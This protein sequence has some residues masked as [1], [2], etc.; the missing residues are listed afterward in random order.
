MS[1]DSWKA[2]EGDLRADEVET[3]SDAPRIQQ[4]VTMSA[5]LQSDYLIARHLGLTDVANSLFTAGQAIAAAINPR[6][7]AQEG[8]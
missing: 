8:T 7:T 1:Y 6:P 5:R 3:E 4:L 2:D